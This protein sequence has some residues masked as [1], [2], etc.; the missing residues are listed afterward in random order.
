MAGSSVQESGSF[1]GMVGKFVKEAL[2]NRVVM[3]AAGVLASRAAFNG[4][5][6]VLNI[7]LARMLGV[8]GLGIYTYALAWMF[9]LMVPT[10]LGMDQLVVREIAASAVRA[11]WSRVRGVLR[12]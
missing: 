5:S 8:S 12:K 6:F 7:I 1:P 4:L 3:G 2:G 11:E 10:M 9:L